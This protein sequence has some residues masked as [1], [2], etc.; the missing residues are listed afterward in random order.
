M[1]ITA[2]HANVKPNTRTKVFMQLKKK[3]NK[4]R[5]D[6]DDLKEPPGAAAAPVRRRAARGPP[7]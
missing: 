6:R 3:E 2:K 7:R 4:H 1:K 5:H